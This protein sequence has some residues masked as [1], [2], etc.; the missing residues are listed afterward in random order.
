MTKNKWLKLTA[1][2]VILVMLSGCGG[3][4]N[5]AGTTGGDNT[6]GGGS[7]AAADADKIYKAN[8]VT[9]HGADLKG[10]NLDTVGSRMTKDEIAEKIRKG[11]GGMIAFEKRLDDA[12]IDAL[13]V[14]LEAKK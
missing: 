14:W 7:V 9:C 11:G 2:A 4:N 10:Q 1:G 8:C 6:A 3:G 5:D 13:A 12:E